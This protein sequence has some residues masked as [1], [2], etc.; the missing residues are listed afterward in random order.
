MVSKNWKIG[1][2][3]VISILA[4]VLES[5]IKYSIV[6]K[7]PAEGFYLFKPILQI[8]YTPNYNIA[9]SLPLALPLILFFVISALV[10]LSFLWRHYLK[11]GNLKLLLAISLVIAGA[12]SN[13]IDRFALGFVVDYINMFI[14]PIFN[15]ADC[16]I[17]A[18]VLI[19]IL[20]E[21]NFKKRV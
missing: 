8:I 21:L 9:F 15:L 7:I 10:F 12:A 3:I 13:L 19:Y 16:L 20:S 4:F 6:N 5:V 17:V 18:G 2:I 11:S 1:A 14:W